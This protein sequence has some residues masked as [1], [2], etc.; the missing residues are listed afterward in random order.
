MKKYH[1]KVEAGMILLNEKLSID[2]TY[3]VYDMVYLIFLKSKKTSA[4]MMR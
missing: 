3:Y 4:M 1:K 2:Y